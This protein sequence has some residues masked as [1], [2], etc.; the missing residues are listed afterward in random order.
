M[1]IVLTI[2]LVACF[3]AP[4]VAMT[5]GVVSYLVLVTAAIV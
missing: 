4:A 2:A 3:I 5:A 1:I